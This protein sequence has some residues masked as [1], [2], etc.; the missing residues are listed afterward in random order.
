MRR[1]NGWGDE[2]TEF[3]L[4]P[5]GLAFIKARLGDTQP[6]PDASL[7]AVLAKVPPSRLPE[8][9][10]IGADRAGA[11]APCPWPEPAGLAGDAQR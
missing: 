5:E 1:W 8:H 3:P 11:R 6:L 4:K 2:R 9:P 7:A 10:L